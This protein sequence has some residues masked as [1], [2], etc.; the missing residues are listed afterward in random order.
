[1]NAAA[2][3][4]LAPGAS[5]VLAG[6]A[7]TPDRIEEAA[8]VAAAEDCEPPT[9]IHASEAYRR[10]LIEVLTR[11]ALKRAFARAAEATEP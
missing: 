10:R 9:D 5:E 4:N 2:T 3:S 7:P 6:S 1:M 11:R 8:R